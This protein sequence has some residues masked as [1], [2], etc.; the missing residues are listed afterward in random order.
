MENKTGKYFKYAI[1]EIVLVVIGI[2][3]ALQI[4]NWNETRKERVKESAYLDRLK[5]DITI[6]SRLLYLNEAFYKDV[7]EYGNQALQY[8]EGEKIASVS[9]WDILVSFFHASQIW[10]IITTSSTFEEL[11]SSGELSLIKNIELRN[12]LSFYHGGGM[13]RYNQT[14]GINPPYRKMVRGLIPSKIQ[15][16]MWDNCH[17][18]DGD[19]QILKKCDP[20]IEDAK[21]IEVLKSLSDN[22]TLIEELRFYMSSIKVGM[23]T[24]LEQQRLCQNMLT[25]IEK[26][27]QTND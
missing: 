23:A 25:E 14:M 2:L 4:N 1:G 5:A 10:P 26:E 18:T 8:V 21:A 20:F 9:N 27:L 24:V 15:N 13:Q 16:F 3:I 6:D 22:V 12:I 11:K 19:I 17:V 7:F